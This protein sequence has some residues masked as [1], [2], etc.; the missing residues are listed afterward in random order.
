MTMKTFKEKA[1]K[2]AMDKC[3]YNTT[4]C[5][6]EY[7]YAWM[8]A[9]GGCQWYDASIHVIKK[10]EDDYIA[11]YRAAFEWI[12]VEDKLPDSDRAILAANFESTARPI[13]TSS[14]NEDGE[15][16]ALEIPYFATF[17]ATHWRE[18]EIPE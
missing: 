16:T 3:P 5:K 6:A 18:I 7:C 1:Y 15:I 12:S 11:G 2:Y 13:W 9:N 14:M 4:S 10:G 8:P 17:S